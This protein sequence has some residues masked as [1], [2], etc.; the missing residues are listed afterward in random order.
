MD[1]KPGIDPGIWLLSA[2]TL[3]VWLL[4]VLALME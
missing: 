3:S 1:R 4:I 2:A